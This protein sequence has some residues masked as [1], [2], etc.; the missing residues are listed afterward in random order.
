MELY[1]HG[2]THG[3]KIPS[4]KQSIEDDFLKMQAIKPSLYIAHKNIFALHAAL[5]E[6]ERRHTALLVQQLQA[7]RKNETSPINIQK[8][9]KEI[10][11][12]ISEYRSAIVGQNNT[13]HS[14]IGRY[15]DD[16]MQASRNVSSIEQKITT[17]NKLIS[18]AQLHIQQFLKPHLRSHTPI[19]DNYPVISK[20][21][22]DEKESVLHISTE[23]LIV[24]ISDIHENILS[25]LQIYLNRIAQEKL[26]TR[27]NIIA[28]S[29]Y[30][31][32]ISLQKK[33]YGIYD[34]IQ[35]VTLDNKY[36]RDHK[37]V[38]QS[39]QTLEK[40]FENIREHM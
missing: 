10:D 13:I 15:K 38:Q 1:K 37:D 7:D 31:I 33:L 5:Q 26:G 28:K 23:A 18:E 17:S 24:Y 20:K 39:L 8:E 21:D 36:L 19:E 3:R 11:E 6:T 27:N 35:E 16:Y 30:N 32:L 22:V 34:N 12:E 40:Y 9:K 25:P 4:I 2:Q 29:S 14:I